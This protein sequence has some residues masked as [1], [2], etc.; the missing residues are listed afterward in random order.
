MEAATPDEQII[1]MKSYNPVDE[2]KRLH[3]SIHH[4]KTSA[5]LL[6]ISIIV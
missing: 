3:D 1:S 5:A 6:Q 4:C 2:K